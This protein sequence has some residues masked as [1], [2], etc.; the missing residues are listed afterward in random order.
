MIVAMTVGLR[1]NSMLIYFKGL[2]PFSNSEQ[3]MLKQVQHDKRMSKFE[4]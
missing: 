3:E 2:L 4:P 1:F